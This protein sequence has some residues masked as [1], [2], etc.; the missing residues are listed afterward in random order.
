LR[1][2]PKS[3]DTQ[4]TPLLNHFAPI[5][6][7]VDVADSAALRAFEVRRDI[8]PVPFWK[9]VKLQVAVVVAVLAGGSRVRWP[10]TIDNDRLEA[11]GLGPGWRSA[12][13]FWRAVIRASN[14]LGP[15][16]RSAFGKSAWGRRT[17]AQ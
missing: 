15:W 12:T 1:T 2:G 8:V 10:K 5:Q 14:N 16:I 3:Q 7:R 4:Q 9:I 11:I 13:P 6:A 17:Q